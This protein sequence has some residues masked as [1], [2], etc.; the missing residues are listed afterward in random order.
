[1]LRNKIDS[2]EKV[3]THHKTLFNFVQCLAKEKGDP[4]LIHKM[5]LAKHYIEKYQN[6]WE[7]V[8]E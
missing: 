7:F 3:F 8:D 4:F 5:Y 6:V 2:S 1:V